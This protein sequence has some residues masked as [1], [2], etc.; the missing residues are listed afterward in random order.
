MNIDRVRKGFVSKPSKLI[1]KII[2]CHPTL[3]GIQMEVIQA[4]EGE[5]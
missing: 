4:L 3:H 1:E 2:R 5:G